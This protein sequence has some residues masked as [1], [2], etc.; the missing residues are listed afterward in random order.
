MGSQQHRSRIG[1]AA[2]RSHVAVFRAAQSRSAAQL[3]DGYDGMGRQNIDGRK[4]ET[5]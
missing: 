4:N 1:L 5:A 2:S 3:S